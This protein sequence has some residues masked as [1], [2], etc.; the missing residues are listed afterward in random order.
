MTI[1]APATKSDA[2][3]DPRDPLARLEKLF[4]AGTVVPLHPRDKSGVLAASGNID[5]VRTIAYCSD[6]TV[7]GGA[8]ASKAASTS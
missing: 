4:D 8:M 2:S 1:L 3:I 6:A 7:M 5:G